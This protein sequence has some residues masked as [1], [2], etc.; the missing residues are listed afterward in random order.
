MEKKKKRMCWQDH[1]L[2]QS[3]GPWPK[4]YMSFYCYKL[5]SMTWRWIWRDLWN[6]TVIISQQMTLH[7]IPFSMTR[8]NI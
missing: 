4:G 1:V 6:S 2:N 5:S 7:V 8:Q 3:S